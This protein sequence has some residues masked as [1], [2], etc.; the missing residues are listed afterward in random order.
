ML[1]LLDKSPSAKCF[2][3]SVVRSSSMSSIPVSIKEESKIIHPVIR[4]SQIRSIPS[5][6]SSTTTKQSI[7]FAPLSL[8]KDVSGLQPTDS[9]LRQ[10]L[11]KSIAGNNLL[12]F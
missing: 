9:N 4:K 10:P 2:R 12:F 8:I 3:A 5:N 6:N 7:T 11:V 1:R